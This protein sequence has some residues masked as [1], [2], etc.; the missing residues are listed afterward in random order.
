MSPSEF[1]A[2]WAQL[3]ETHAGSAND[4]GCFDLENCTSCSGSVFCKD[5]ERCYRARYATGCTDCSDITHCV[6]CRHCH[7]STFCYESESCT[8]SNY[9]VFSSHCSEC[10]YC[11]GCVG[12]VRKDFYILNEPYSRADYFR[13]VERLQKEMG[14]KLP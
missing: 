7:G 4:P 2:Q 8:D 5:C 3:R 13:T 9:L 12:L 14:I 11:F 10:N 6:N 1:R